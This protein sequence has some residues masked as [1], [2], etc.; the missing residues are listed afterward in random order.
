MSSFKVVAALQVLIGVVLGF[1]TMLSAC[2][3]PV[4]ERMVYSS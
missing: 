2:V 4:S 3:L 1:V